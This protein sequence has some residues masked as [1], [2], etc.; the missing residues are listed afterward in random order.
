MH[1][2]TAKGKKLTYKKQMFVQGTIK[3]WFGD[4]EVKNEWVL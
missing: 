1:Q 4:V 2:N 3:I